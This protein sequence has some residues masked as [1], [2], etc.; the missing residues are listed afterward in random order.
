MID[1]IMFNII[2]NICTLIG[3]LFFILI[4]KI[5]FNFDISMPEMKEAPEG[6]PCL[7]WDGRDESNMVF[8]RYLISTGSFMFS[9]VNTRE[10]NFSGKG[11]EMGPR[12]WVYGAYE[13]PTLLKVHVLK[14]DKIVEIGRR[15]SYIDCSPKVDTRPTNYGEMREKHINP[16]KVQGVRLM[17]R[18]F[19]KP[20]KSWKDTTKAHKSW[21]KRM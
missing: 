17:E 10:S 5:Q 9:N 11:V 12:M 14:G 13:V 2:T 18:D 7:E 21:G 6:I 19:R 3:L 15:H 1:I 8:Y 16:K 4:N 20:V